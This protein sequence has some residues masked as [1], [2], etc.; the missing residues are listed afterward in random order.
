MFAN[1]LAAKVSAKNDELNYRM[2]IADALKA[3]SENTAKLTGGSYIQKR[4]ADILNPT[5]KETRTEQEVI[6]MLSEKLHKLA[7][8]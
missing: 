1:Y 5:P 8:E 3:I 7:T 4:Y 6:S 2:Y